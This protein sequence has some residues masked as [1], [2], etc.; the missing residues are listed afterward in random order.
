[1]SDQ[2]SLTR[3][4]LLTHSGVFSIASV[5]YLVSLIGA[6][7]LGFSTWD[8]LAIVSFILSLFNIRGAWKGFSDME[9]GKANQSS[10]IA[11]ITAIGAALLGFL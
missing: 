10:W 3:K 4:S 7:T 11:S 6:L 9:Y 1:M 5:G 8:Y 2:H